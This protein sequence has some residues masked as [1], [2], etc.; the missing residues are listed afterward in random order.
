[1]TEADRAVA[2]ELEGSGI[3]PPVDPRVRRA[4]WWLERFAPGIGSRWAVELWC[5]PP[6]MESNLRMPPG[7]TPGEPIEARWNGYR[8]VGESWGEGPPVYLVHGWGGRRPHLGMFVKPLIESGHRVIAFDLP[9]HNE[10]EAGALKPGRTTAI[11]CAHA[12]GAMIRE[13]G[14]ARAVVAH[15]LGANA[16]TFAIAY[17]AK[18]ERLVYLAP[19]GEFPLYLDY[20]AKR[21]GFGPRIRAGLHRGLE[22]RIEMPLYET[23]MTVVGARTGYPPLLLI[24]DPDDPDTPYETSQRVVASWPGARLMTTKGLGRLAHYRILRHRPAIRAGVEFI[25]PSTL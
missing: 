1:M 2:V 23:N 15:S 20:F 8:V 17:G 18:V 10:S 16:T 13:H 19:M 12:V 7:V 3:E 4:F 22:R 25:G 24:H 21:H 5:T 11:E 9:S 6:V 14:P